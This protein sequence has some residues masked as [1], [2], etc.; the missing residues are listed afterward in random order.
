MIVG[1]TVLVYLL[2]QRL[3]VLLGWVHGSGLERLALTT[4]WR[5]KFWLL[6]ELLRSGFASW[7]RLHSLAWELPVAGLTLAAVGAAIPGRSF[8]G[9][10]TGGGT[11]RRGLF[12]LF[13]FLASISPLLVASENNAS[14]RSLPVLYATVTFLAVEGAARWRRNL[15]AW[16]GTVAAGWL[17]L[18]MGASAAYHVRAGLVQPN[19][20]EYG[21][22]SQLVRRQFRAMPSQMVYLVPPPVLLAPATMKPSWGIRPGFLAVLLGDETLPAAGFS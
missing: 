22:V 8:A 18:L 1:A 3:V 2:G 16:G 7:A 10:L 17:V 21:A 4:D 14:Y 13:M 15:P 5:A 19:V 9:G 20:R 6:R 11:V 12:A